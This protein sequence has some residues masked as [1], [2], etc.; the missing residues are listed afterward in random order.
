MFDS[1]RNLVKVGLRLITCLAPR[2]TTQVIVMRKLRKKEEE[3][4][5]YLQ[6]C[7]RFYSPENNAIN[8]WWPS[9]WLIKRTLLLIPEFRNTEQNFPDSQDGCVLSLQSH[10]HTYGV[11]EAS[12]N[13]ATTSHPDIHLPVPG[14]RE[15]RIWTDLDYL[16]L[17]GHVILLP[18][19]LLLLQLL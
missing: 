9:A 15:N 10:R 16:A 2:F 17:S 5:Y 1:V 11:P 8:S 12:L 19:M 7:L 4:E 14:E 3:E 18:R 13:E 6:F